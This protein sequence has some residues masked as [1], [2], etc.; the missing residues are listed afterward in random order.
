MR[1][2]ALLLAAWSRAGSIAWLSR[3]PEKDWPAFL[4]EALDRYYAVAGNA[5]NEHVF[6]FYQMQA[7]LSRPDNTSS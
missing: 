3:L 1:W 2:V 5:P 6:K 7:A 4:N